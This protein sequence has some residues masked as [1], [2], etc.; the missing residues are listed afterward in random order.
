MARFLSRE[1][2][3]ELRE[4]SAQANGPGANGTGANGP[5]ANGEA[6]PDLVVEVAVADAPEG[7]VRYQLVVEGG[8]VRAVAPGEATWPAGLSLSSDYATLSEVASGRLAAFEALA[9]GRA[10]ISGDTSA[11]SSAQSLAGV[12]LVPPALRAATTF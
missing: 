7:E 4:L 1:W 11:L 8:R 9:G 3:E 6:E 12:E 2:F 10:K 5:G